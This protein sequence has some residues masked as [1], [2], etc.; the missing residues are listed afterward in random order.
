MVKDVLISVGE[1]EYGT[2][3][4]EEQRSLDFSSGWVVGA[5]RTEH[6]QGWKCCNDGLVVRK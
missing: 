5:I 4:E 6:C 3:S 2:L 1:T